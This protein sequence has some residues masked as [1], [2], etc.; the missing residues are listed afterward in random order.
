MTYSPKEPW[1]GQPHKSST[2]GISTRC[3][4]QRCAQTECPSGQCLEQPDPVSTAGTCTGCCQLMRDPMYHHKGVGCQTGQRVSIAWISKKKCQTTE[5]TNTKPEL[6]LY[7]EYQCKWVCLISTRE[8]LQRN[9]FLAKCTAWVL[10]EA[11][12]QGVLHSTWF[13]L[14]IYILNRDDL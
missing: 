9:Y 1:F 3:Y 5:P 10:C 13:H 7:Y 14:Q 6:L 12:R 11:S 2:A 8:K 4:Q